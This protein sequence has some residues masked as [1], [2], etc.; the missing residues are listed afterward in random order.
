MASA[1]SAS[2]FKTSISKGNISPVYFVTGTEPL[3]LDSVIATV[4]SK[5]VDEAS[6][7]FNYDVLHGDNVTAQNIAAVLGELPMMAQYRVILLKNAESATQTV[8]K[9]L[10][11]YCNKPNPDSILVLIFNGEPKSAW[12][13]NI[14]KV[15]VHVKCNTPKKENEIAAWINSR[16]KS[17]KVTIDEEALDLLSSQRSVQ[18]ID[19]AGELEKAS[20]LAGENGTITQEIVQ[21][22]WGIEPEVNIWGYFDRVAS[23][24]R[25]EALKDFHYF[26]TE[27]ESG[28][29]AGFHLS[30]IGKRL[31]MVW[32]ERVYDQQH[33]PFS[34]RRWQGNSLMQ[35]KL[36][37][38]TLRKMPI[39]AVESSLDD[40][41]EFDELR[42]TRS[43]SS[44]NMF[45]SML[46]KIALHRRKGSE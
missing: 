6:R 13:K 21:L 44:S 33:V 35:W 32:K 11:D 28:Q 9:Y 34:I 14:L 27:Y 23:G 41:I 39:E 15:S 4:S 45:E 29:T 16:A 25:E 22:V 10:L 17:L 37:S 40:L 20:L 46:H 8:Q 36:A 18:L 12:A 3:L 26:R 24:N 38:S 31:K 30:Q 19:L 43:V 5:L 42:K 2:Q 7:D 1:L